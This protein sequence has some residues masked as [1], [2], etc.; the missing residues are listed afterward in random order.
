MRVSKRL[1]IVAVLAWMMFALAGCGSLLSF[2]KSTPTYIP[3]EPAKPLQYVE[4]ERQALEYCRELTD[5]VFEWGVEAKNEAVGQAAELLGVLVKSVGSPVESVPMEVSSDPSPQTGE[6]P[7]QSAMLPS[8][9]IAA[10]IRALQDDIGGY[11]TALVE[12]KAD[13]ERVR[14]AEAGKPEEVKVGSGVLGWLTGLPVALL[15]VL[16]V[17]GAISPGLLVAI[18]KRVVMGIMAARRAL[19]EVVKG[20]Q[21]FRDGLKAEAKDAMSNEQNLNILDALLADNQSK[22]TEVR[23]VKEKA[24]MKLK[25]LVGKE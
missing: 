6:D 10:L 9:G 20:I 23:V 11:R 21:E 22:S 14:K 16:V 2:S 7:E 8:S 13:V 24:R 4:H 19:P 15:V 25:E 17:I 12:Y 3:P 5:R 18:I 1:L